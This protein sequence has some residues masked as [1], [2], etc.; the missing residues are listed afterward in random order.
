[1]ARTA[2]P[3]M[4]VAMSDS[5]PNL[6]PADPPADARRGGP[7]HWWFSTPLWSRV[8]AAL[9]LGIAFGI[10]APDSWVDFVAP[11]G[12]L[13][14]R[15]IRMLVAP[16]VLATLV[17][18]VVSLGELGR[19]GAMGVRA[20]AFYLV[21]TAFAIVLGLAFGAVFQPG[22]GV[23]LPAEATVEERPAPPGLAE[24]LVNLVPDNP[25]AALVNA[26]VLPIIVFALLLGIGIVL[27]G[28]AGEPLAAFFTSLSEVM[29]VVTGIVME[30]TPF[31]VFALIAV[32]VDENGAAALGSLLKLLLVYYAVA[33]THIGLT[34]GMTVRFVLGLPLLR[35]F[36]GILDAQSVALSTCSSSGTL[37]VT[38][39]CV[40]ENLG[41]GRATAGFVLPLGATINMDGTAA[42]LGIV[43]L[44]AAQIAGVDLGMADY[45]TIVLTATLSSIGAAG[46]PGASLVLLSTVLLSV[47]GLPL[48]VIG[49]VAAVDRLSDMV[50]TAVNVTGDALAALFVAKTTGD[51]DE[52]VYRADAVA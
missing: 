40:T 20:V 36:R 2:A 32:N 1:M 42:W 50:R 33:L 48:E 9:L 34:Y 49:F 17:A 26:D 5:T 35:F 18:G 45:V 25:F 6:S 3:A 14:L 22:A 41:V 8:I 43:A 37:A 23:K 51:F 11:V 30:L 39:V 24:R 7:L 12:E 44:F 28:K 13:F 46:I 31:G 15:S 19:M 52:S 29:L 47:P 10:W 38:T 27:A 16:L 21:T 4:M